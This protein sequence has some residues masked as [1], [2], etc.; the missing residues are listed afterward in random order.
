MILVAFKVDWLRVD[1]CCVDVSVAKHLHHVK[2]VLRL[3]VFH[4]GFPMSE[5]VE[6]ERARESCSAS[7]LLRCVMNI[8]RG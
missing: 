8:K 2:D 4:C 6:S 1:Q 5:S 7:I 3:V